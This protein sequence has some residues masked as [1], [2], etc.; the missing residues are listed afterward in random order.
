MG[1][2]SSSVPAARKRAARR[3][4]EAAERIALER[5]PDLVP[6]SPAREP[7]EP[8]YV[9]VPGFGRLRLVETREDWERLVAESEAR[10]AGQAVPGAFK[11]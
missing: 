5:A 1:S 3:I 11:S 6:Q 7:S 2:S 4:V 10:Q 8:E 9:D